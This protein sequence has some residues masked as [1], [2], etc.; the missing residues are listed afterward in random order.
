M[1]PRRYALLPLVI[2]GC[3]MT[4]GQALVIGG[5]HFYV[6][7]VLILVGLARIIVRREWSTTN[8]TPIDGV[9]VAWLLL[10][11]FL[12]LLFDGTNVRLTQRLGYAYDV[13]GIYALVRSSVRTID[14]VIFVIKLCA[15][16]IIPLGVLFAVESITG[17]NPFAA[18]GGVNLFSELRDGRV[19]ST[20]PFQH[21]ILAGTLGATVLPLFIGLW[22]C[23]KANWLLAG[24]A[25]VAAATIIIASASSGPFSALVV[26][27]AALLC[28]P[29]RSYMRVIRWAL[30]VVLLVLAVPMKEPV[31]FLIARVSDLT[32]GGG[33]YRSALIDAA[34]RHFDEW[35]LI[36]TGYTRHWMPSGIS[37]DPNSADIVNEFINQGIRGGLLTV[38][39]FVWLIVK[40]FK[41]VGMSVHNTAAYSTEVRFL[42][43]SLGCA[44]L[45]HVASFFSVSYFDQIR[46]FWVMLLGM[47]AALEYQ[48]KKA[49]VHCSP[50]A[51]ENSPSR[52]ALVS[53]R[54]YSGIKRP[55]MKAARK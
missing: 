6:M 12:Y 5:L 22:R 43:W 46:I 30:V 16:A 37:A 24:C 11:S 55:Q 54:A 29:L 41:A 53:A 18:F 51:I 1:L 33:W 40:C 9:F 42:I 17:R 15:I 48:A 50:P 39:V 36:G 31:W 26:S 34:V 38:L 7:R 23:G 20:G 8:P 4:L 49:S 19:R 52:S 27:T 2:A 3:Y 21:P 45:A 14:D 32:G 44:L 10:T 28:W 13:A 47:I 25:I 35:W